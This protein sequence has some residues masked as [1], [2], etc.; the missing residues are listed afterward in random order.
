MECPVC[1]ETRSRCDWSK[2]QWQANGGAGSPWVVP[3]SA[4]TQPAIEL[5]SA[6]IATTTT[7]TGALIDGAP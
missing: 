6:L 5:I 3:Q 7:A 4:A 2:P 1:G